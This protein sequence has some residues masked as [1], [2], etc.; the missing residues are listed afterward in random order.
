M[1]RIKLPLIGLKSTLADVAM[2]YATS[3]LKLGEGHECTLGLLDVLKETAEHYFEVNCPPE[4]DENGN[5]LPGRSD[6]G[7]DPERC[8]TRFQT[9]QLLHQTAVLNGAKTTI[10]RG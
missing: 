5:E 9:Q 7:I 1:A 10:D 4:V 6:Y 8:L 3:K 2:A